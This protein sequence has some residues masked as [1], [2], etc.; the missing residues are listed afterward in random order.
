MPPGQPIPTVST[1][2]VHIEPKT[3]DRAQTVPGTARGRPEPGQTTLGDTLSK[4]KVGIQTYITS[5]WARLNSAPF[6]DKKSE[7]QHEQRP[8]SPQGPQALPPLIPLQGGPPTTLGDSYTDGYASEDDFQSV[9]SGD[10]ESVTDNPPDNNPGPKAENA[11]TQDPPTQ[12]ILGINPSEGTSGETPTLGPNQLAQ[13]TPSDS[14]QDEEE[15]TPQEREG[16]AQHT[17]HRR[18]NRPPGIPAIRGAVSAWISFF[19]V[20]RQ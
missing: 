3:P 5:H 13:N 11:P 4:F 19:D 2:R 16:I 18:F 9:H 17:P 8:V 14:P 20:Y 10:N 1:N 6:S 12:E 15:P 7:P